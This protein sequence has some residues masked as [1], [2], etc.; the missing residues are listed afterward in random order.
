MKNKVFW[1]FI[2]LL[3]VSCNDIY[4]SSFENKS[5]LSLMQTFS[6]YQQYNLDISYGESNYHLIIDDKSFYSV[7]KKITY[8][9][10][11][12]LDNYQKYDNEKIIDSNYILEFDFIGHFSLLLD[13]NNFTKN[14]TKLGADYVLNN[15]SKDE[16]S[17]DFFDSQISSLNIKYLEEKQT[18]EY[19]YVFSDETIFSLV[20]SPS[21]VDIYYF[22]KS[23]DDYLD[24]Y[25][26][27]EKNYDEVISLIE[28]KRD[29]VLILISPNCSACENA[30]DLY[31]DFSLEYSSRE[32][33]ALDIKKLN[34]SQTNT[35]ISYFKNTYDGQDEFLKYPSYDT[36]PKDYFLTPTAVRFS[37]GKAK[38]VLLA[39]SKN[40]EEEF[41]YLSFL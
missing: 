12:F 13:V 28:E 5:L 18:I 39:F 15:D 20:Y 17:F 6:Y 40:L 19:K 33:Y 25:K 7:D 30:R 14:F 34:S 3:L 16:Y 1:A 4:D 37:D 21:E 23:R 36:Y 10:Y 29:F 24:F 35:I 26:N 38:Y 11:T 32:Y 8:Y 22:Q 2:S 9:K 31:Y 41:Y 27:F